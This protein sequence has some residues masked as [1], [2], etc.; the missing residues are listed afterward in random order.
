MYT[1]EWYNMRNNIEKS[2]N[3]LEKFYELI[4]SDFKTYDTYDIDQ[5]TSID[6][7]EYFDLSYSEIEIETESI[8]S[9]SSYFFK[10]DYIL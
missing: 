2:V 7:S 3:S 10:S 5:N 6:L 9:D 4:W 1:S 8:S